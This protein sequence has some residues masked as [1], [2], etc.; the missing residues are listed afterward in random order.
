MAK[1]KSPEDLKAYLAEHL[2]YERDMLR[3]TYSML[4]Q[5]NGLRWCAMFES[6]GLHARNLYDFLRHEGQAGN[7]VRACDFVEGHKKPQHSNIDK[8]MNESFFHL[9]TLR[10]ENTAINLP[11]AIEI[12]SWID[13]EWAN[14]AAQLSETFKGFVDTSPACPPLSPPTPAHL[15][16]TNHVTTTSSVWVPSDVTIA[17]IEKRDGC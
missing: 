5:M 13:R 10:L 6:F 15:S 3:F 8:K 17:P 12:G 7:T 9:S 1:Q 16:A 2:T 4:F 11:D 14:W